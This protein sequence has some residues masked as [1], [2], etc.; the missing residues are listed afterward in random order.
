MAIVHVL[1][2]YSCLVHSDVV[3]ESTFYTDDEVLKLVVSK[4]LFVSV[5][6][7]ASSKSSPE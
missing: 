1:Q 7:A 3:K 4:V 2:I 5:V 6:F